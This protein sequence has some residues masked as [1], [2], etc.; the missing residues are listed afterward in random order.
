VYQLFAAITILAAVVL[1]LTL[2]ACFLVGSLQAMIMTIAVTTM[3][4]D[5]TAGYDHEGKSCY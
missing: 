2:P 1:S 4:V 3:Y 5:D